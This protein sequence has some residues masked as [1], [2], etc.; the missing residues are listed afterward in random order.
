MRACELPDTKLITLL[1]E[2]T[3]HQV[4]G[5][6]A[7]NQKNPKASWDVFHQEYMDIRK[8]AFAIPEKNS[9]FLGSI[10]PEAYVSIKLSA[11]ALG[12]Y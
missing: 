7:T 10:P 5:G 11:D 6:I 12:T 1:G 9:L 2:G 8:K 3:F 4:H